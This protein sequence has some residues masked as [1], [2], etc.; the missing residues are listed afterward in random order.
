MTIVLPQTDSMLYTL[1]YSQGTD[2]QSIDSVTEEMHGKRGDGYVSLT[3]EDQ[4]KRPSPR[5]MRQLGDDS[6]ED[7]TLVSN[8]NIPSP[9][10]ESGVGRS[11]WKND[12]DDIIRERYPNWKGRYEF[13]NK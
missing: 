5:K 10:G 6:I 4:A 7:E 8:Y 1:Y 11:F 9:F 2:K 3:E 13:L 12:I